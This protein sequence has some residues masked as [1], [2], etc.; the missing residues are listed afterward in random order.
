[1]NIR[2]KSRLWI[3]QFFLNIFECIV[4]ACQE[5]GSTGMSPMNHVL[6]ND[7]SNKCIYTIT[8]NV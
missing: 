6:N 3:L 4:V 8:V 2:V 5:F 1:M 7:M